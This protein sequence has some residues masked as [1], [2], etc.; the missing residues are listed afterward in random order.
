[1]LFHVVNERHRRH[2]P[3]IFTTNK[4]LKTRASTPSEDR[5]VSDQAL[6]DKMID[7]ARLVTLNQPDDRASRFPR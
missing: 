6:A 2:R 1:M 4:S 7:A 3:M 5:E